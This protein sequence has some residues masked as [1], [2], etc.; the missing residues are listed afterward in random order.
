MME[1][2]AGRILKGHKASYEIL[3]FLKRQSVAKAKTLAVG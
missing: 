3:A 2:A 1:H